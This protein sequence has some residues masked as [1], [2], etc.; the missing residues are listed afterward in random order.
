[1]ARRAAA[2]GGL[3][4]LGL[5]LLAVVAAG[6][7]VR[8]KDEAGAARP[9][10]AATSAP[11]AGKQVSA[12]ARYLTGGDGA[13][14]L[15]ALR[16]RVVLVDVG[17][18]WSTPCRAGV[19]DLNRVQE[20]LAPRGLSVVGLVVDRAPFGDVSSA[21]QGLGAIYPVALASPD[22]AQ[23][24]GPVRALPTRVLLDRK[25]GVRK[26]YAGAVPVDQIK[27][28]IAALLNEG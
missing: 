7:Q 17:A 18:T 2:G 9:V 28:D 15:A 4:L 8:T 27:A 1:M 22:Y 6:C 21:A 20:E 26:V 19:P 13:L 23:Q 10:A 11:L 14:D 12:S 25:G 24:F 3:S 5:A 16:G